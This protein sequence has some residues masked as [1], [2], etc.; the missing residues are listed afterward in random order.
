[1]AFQS[2]FDPRTGM[3]SSGVA[4]RVT[5]CPI[6][7]PIRFSPKSNAI[8]VV[9]SSIVPARIECGR[10]ACATRTSCRRATDFGAGERHLHRMVSHPT[11]GYWR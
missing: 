3:V 2:G 8:S 1:M 9:V 4:V 7:V 10:E 11:G 6:A 5:V